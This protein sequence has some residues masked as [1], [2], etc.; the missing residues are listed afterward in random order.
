VLLPFANVV[1][2][3]SSISKAEFSAR[4]SVG[5]REARETCYWLK[6]LFHGAYLDEKSLES[7][8]TGCDELCKL[9]YSILKSSGR[10][11]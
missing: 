8:V 9:L 5:Y 7:M 6:L 11:Y 1:E 2:A 3:D 10:I 4:I